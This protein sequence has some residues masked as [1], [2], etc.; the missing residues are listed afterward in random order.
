MH[1]SPALRFLSLL[2]LT[3]AIAAATDW[4][5]PNGSSIQVFIDQASSGDRIFVEPGTYPGGISYRG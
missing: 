3:P 4:T 5:V 2:L 1:K